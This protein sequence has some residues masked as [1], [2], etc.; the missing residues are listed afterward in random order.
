MEAIGEPA[1]DYGAHSMRIGG[2]TA[3][4]A[5]GAQPMDIRVLGRW[6]SECY[7]LY[8]RA[9]RSSARSWSRRIG[10][11]AFDALQ[12]EFEEVDFY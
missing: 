10:S 8:C 2:A 9:V 3:A 4:F 12:E 11:Q 5:A 7:R 1:G 6:D